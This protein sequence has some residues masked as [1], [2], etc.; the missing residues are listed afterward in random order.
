MGRLA[1][2]FPDISYLITR[3]LDIAEELAAVPLFNSPG[4]TDAHRQHLAQFVGWG[5]V[6]DGQNVTSQGAV[7]HCF[8]ILRDGA[9]VVSSLDEQGR[10][11][12]RTY[13]SRG[14]HYG[15]TSLLAGKTRDVTVRAVVAP[16]HDN[17][18]SVRGADILTLD[19]RDLEYAFAERP[20][21]W[22]RGI[23]LFDNY[24]KTKEEKKR[25]VWQTEG[26]VIIWY[27]RP[28]IWWLIQ[29]LLLL[30]VIAIF[31]GLL[32]RARRRA[33]GMRPRPS[34]S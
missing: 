26:E 16:A 11:R 8:V 25:F 4:M 32:A 22:K 15:S 3:P 1:R 6:P 29:P 28:H 21:L 19:R 17:L 24:Q 12:P 20:D 33:F 9:A 30:A 10:L 14:K 13:L 5:F 34:G 23:G 18:P 2:A 7:G 27:G 31:T